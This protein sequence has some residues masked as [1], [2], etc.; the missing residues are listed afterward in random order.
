MAHDIIKN[1]KKFE[2]V[3]PN[4]KSS[5]NTKEVGT[6]PN[7]TAALQLAKYN[8]LESLEEHVDNTKSND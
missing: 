2:N 8:G 6:N 1:G 3:P 4:D 5:R 7:L